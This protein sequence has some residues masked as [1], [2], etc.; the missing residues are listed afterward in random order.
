M[1]PATLTSF[2][3]PWHP[4]SRDRVEEE[5]AKDIWDVRFIHGAGYPAHRSEYR[6]NFGAL[7]EPF[8]AIIKR[9]LRFLMTQRSHNKCA[10]AI[11]HLR[12]FVDFFKARYPRAC[13]FQQLSRQDIEAY[14]AY[15]HHPAGKAMREYTPEERAKQA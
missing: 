1:Q 14:L 8:C 7:P 15:L 3:L 12:L 13:D 11:R 2:P 10:E 6:L 9:Y 5:M 4:V